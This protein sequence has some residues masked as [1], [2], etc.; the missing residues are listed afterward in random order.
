MLRK[1]GVP[2]FYSLLRNSGMTSLHRS[3]ENYGLS[4][5]LGGAEGRLFEITEIYAR[6]AHLLAYPETSGEDIPHARIQSDLL[7]DSRFPLTDREA[8]WWTM[9]VDNG[10]PER[11]E[12][13]RRNGLE[14]HLF[15]P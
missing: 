15:C 1:F 7:D 3:P 4:L 2:K 9:V 13:S 8:I 5:I 11:S 14:A 12:P 10:R 6:L